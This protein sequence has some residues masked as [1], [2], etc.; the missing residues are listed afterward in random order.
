VR[1]ELRFDD[2]L[3]SGMAAVAALGDRF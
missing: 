2:A 1:E 3:R